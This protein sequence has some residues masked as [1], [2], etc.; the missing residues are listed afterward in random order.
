MCELL[1]CVS[2]MR[3]FSSFFFS[4]Q[5]LFVEWT[6]VFCGIACDSN[7]GRQKYENCTFPHCRARA[8]VAQHS[9]TLGT[10]SHHFPQ[11]EAI[12]AA[13][14]WAPK[15]NI[16]AIVLGMVTMMSV[17]LKVFNIDLTTW[18]SAEILDGHA[19]GQTTFE[20][21]LPPGMLLGRDLPRLE[22]DT[23]K[24]FPHVDDTRAKRISSRPGPGSKEEKS[25][26]VCNEEQSSTTV[27]A[28]YAKANLRLV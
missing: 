27:Q 2:G 8:Q 23:W 26:G 28:A 17:Y 6:W 15:E 20:M 11:K 13:C 22:R 12:P 1:V 16:P 9:F 3:V 25:A 10:S 14:Q 5:S 18:I 19:V 21:K 24:N 7:I 4:T